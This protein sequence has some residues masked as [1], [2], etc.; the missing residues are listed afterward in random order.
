MK[1][2]MKKKGFTLIELIVVIAI[3]GILAAIAVPRLSG[4]MIS[5]K[6]SAD[7]AT[8][9][10]IGKAVQQYNAT[11]NT[12]TVPTPAN[13][14]GASLLE[15]KAFVPQDTTY[16]GFNVTITN[17]QATVSYASSAAGTAATAWGT[18]VSSKVLYPVP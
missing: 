15:D 4:F 16:P 14:S 12:T 9:A 10:S 18:I 11:N 1:K 17:G 5:S 3:L 8:A 2:N 13:L 6:T 7:K